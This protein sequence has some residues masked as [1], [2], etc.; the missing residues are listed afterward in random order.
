ML[1]FKEAF[2]KYS[3]CGLKNFEVDEMCQAQ[4]EK[5]DASFELSLEQQIDKL[6]VKIEEVKM[7]NIRTHTA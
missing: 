2:S 4:F 6:K 5:V 1:R 3:N 7:L